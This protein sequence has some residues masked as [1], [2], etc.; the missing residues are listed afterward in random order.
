MVDK[1][2]IQR[3]EG[4]LDTE[5]LIIPC[6]YVI[7]K[8]TFK[9]EL[10]ERYFKPLQKGQ[11]ILDFNPGTEGIWKEI[12]LSEV[13]YLALEQNPYVRSLLEDHNISVM[14]WK[15]PRIPLPDGSVDYALSTPFIEH[16][17]TYVDAINFLI[18]VRRILRPG[19][20]ILLI[21]PNYLSQ[22]EIFFEDYKHGW[23]TSKKRLVD[24]LLDCHYDILG[25]RYTIGWITMRRN[26]GISILRFIIFL[27]MCFLR[28]NIVER[29][30]EATKLHSFA[31]RFKKTFFE[32]IV[33]EAQVPRGK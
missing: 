22:K 12:D 26:P 16:L 7:M 5:G 3:L 20:K 13:Q 8:N 31:Y 9:K 21:V 33:I 25:T 29:L 6:D 17:P 14:D 15:V 28:L 1:S 27:V 18:E 4:G 19:G 30:V 23:I 10:L 11:T 24:M 2:M 32:L